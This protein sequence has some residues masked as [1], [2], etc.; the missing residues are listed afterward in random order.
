MTERRVATSISEAGGREDLPEEI[1]T[2]CL[3]FFPA[4]Q[5]RPRPTRGRNGY[6]A[7][8]LAMQMQK[9]V[10]QQSF[11]HPRGKISLVRLAKKDSRKEIRQDTP[12]GVS[13]G[14]PTGT[15]IVGQMAKNKLAPSTVCLARESSLNIPD[16]PVPA[17]LNC[18][19]SRSP[20]DPIE[21]GPF[22]GK[23]RR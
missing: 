5:P 1:M 9:P 21:N 23:G 19:H 7:R 8:S 13:A 14:T 18:Y 15:V 22:S 3:L 20:V 4:E 11:H 16:K 6:P 10:Q 12:F 17:S 2:N